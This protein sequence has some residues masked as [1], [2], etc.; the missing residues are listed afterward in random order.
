MSTSVPSVV[1]SVSG[2]VSGVL[3]VAGVGVR[4]VCIGGERYIDLRVT[5][6]RVACCVRVG[7]VLVKILAWRG[8]VIVAT[9]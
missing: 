6:I 3:V 1:A 9:I 7:V 8:V 5:V 4:S 2:W